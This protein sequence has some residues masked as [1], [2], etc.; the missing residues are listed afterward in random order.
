MGAYARC[1]SYCEGA[2]E[3]LAGEISEA[4]LLSLRVQHARVRFH[5][6]S[7]PADTLR[8]CA[9]LLADATPPRPRR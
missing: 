8:V 4:D 7:T 1:E 2:I 6:G 9:E 3:Q 5:T